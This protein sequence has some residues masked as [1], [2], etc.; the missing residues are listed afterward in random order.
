MNSAI[1]TCIWVFAVVAC[2]AAWV[3]I[4]ADRI[5]SKAN[6][7]VIV[8]VILTAAAVAGPYWTTMQVHPNHLLSTIVALVSVAIILVEIVLHVMPENRNPLPFFAG[9]YTL[10]AAAPLGVF[11]LVAS[12]VW[13]RPIP[14]G[15]RSELTGFHALFGI[16]CIALAIVLRY[17]LSART[18]RT[19]R[20][21]AIASLVFLVCISVAFFGTS[22]LQRDEVLVGRLYGFPAFLLAAATV[23]IPSVAALI[24]L[25]YPTSSRSWKGRILALVLPKPGTGHEGATNEPPE[26]GAGM[27]RPLIPGL[28]CVATWLVCVFVGTGSLVQIAGTVVPWRV[29]VF[30]SIQWILTVPWMWLLWPLR[31]LLSSMGKESGLY[32]VTLV[33]VLSGLVVYWG[34]ARFFAPSR[35][36]H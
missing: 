15:P 36:T 30:E 9:L 8:Q 35:P 7:K 17:R 29:A 14:G 12:D 6:A 28:A 23:L 22:P 11:M 5:V 24:S 16:L 19:I 4:F 1:G 32:I 26:V 25:R 21:S 33:G 10:V 18:P 27:V 13:T 31:P 20:V 2:A 34:L 3:V